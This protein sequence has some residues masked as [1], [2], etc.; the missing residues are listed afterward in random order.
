[1]INNP[2]IEYDLKH[3]NSVTIYPSFNT[4]FENVIPLYKKML[5]EYGQKTFRGITYEDFFNI[6]AS[7]YD[8]NDF[9]YWLLYLHLRYIPTKTDNQFKY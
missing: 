2:N 4:H 1:M 9:T 5:S 7:Y 3:F 6:L 8:S